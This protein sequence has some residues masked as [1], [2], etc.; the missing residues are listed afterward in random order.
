MQPDQNNFVVAAGEY[1]ESRCFCS[2]GNNEDTEVYWQFEDGS[3]VPKKNNRNRNRAHHIEL[4]NRNGAT[5]VIP[6]LSKRW[7]GVY[8]CVGGQKV[9][10]SV[11]IKIEQTPG[12]S[13]HIA[14]LLGMLMANYI[15]RSNAQ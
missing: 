1:V 4:Q 12:K 6:S 7:E 13:L 2:R 14:Q 10:E 3:K 11:T 8:R 15:C 9:T 5:L